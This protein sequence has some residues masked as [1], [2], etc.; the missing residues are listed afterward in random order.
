MPKTRHFASCSNFL[1]LYPAFR[2][3]FPP[4]LSIATFLFYVLLRGAFF[5]LTWSMNAPIFPCTLF[6]AA[7]DNSAND[8]NWSRKCTF[9]AQNYFP[10]KLLSWQ[11]HFPGAKL[12]G[13]I[14][15]FTQQATDISNILPSHYFCNTTSWANHLECCFSSRHCAFPFDLRVSCTR[16]MAILFSLI[17]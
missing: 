14:A 11:I 16:A 3:R 12:F 7:H 10:G 5:F 8:Y 2:V 15:D 9:L 13:C 4:L 6:L 17:L 1:T